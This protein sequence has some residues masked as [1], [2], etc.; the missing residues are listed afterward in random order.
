MKTLRPRVARD[1][2]PERI[3]IDPDGTVVAYFG[4]EPSLRYATLAELLE[5][6]DLRLDDLTDQ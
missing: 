2:L 4:A 3:V 5:H 1:G 6:Y